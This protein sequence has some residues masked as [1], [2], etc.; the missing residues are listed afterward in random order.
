MLTLGLEDFYV[1][2]YSVMSEA[3][4]AVLTGNLGASIQS[5]SRDNLYEQVSPN[6][7]AGELLASLID[8]YII[9]IEEGAISYKQRPYICICMCKVFGYKTF[10]YMGI[11]NA[12]TYFMLFM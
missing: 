3:P 8:H 10:S 1:V 7:H 4:V 2:L 5:L 12:L 11:Q 9:I 6:L